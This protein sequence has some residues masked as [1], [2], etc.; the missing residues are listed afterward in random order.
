VLSNKNIPQIIECVGPE[1]ITFKEI[2]NKLLKL[3]DKKRILIPQ[4]LFLA[5]I[6]AKFFQLFP[7]PLITQDQLKLLKYDNILTGNYKSNSDIG[8]PSTR[9]F[10]Q[11]VEK[12]SYMWREGGQFNRK[13][14]NKK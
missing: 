6:L 7:K 3:I 10:D 9:V 13:S 8:I 4:P 1:E 11:E 5:N 2:I 12:Y 14:D